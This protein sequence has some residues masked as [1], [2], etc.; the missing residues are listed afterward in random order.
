MSFIQGAIFD[1][2]WFYNNIMYIIVPLIFLALFI[3]A[4]I[5]LEMIVLPGILVIIGLIYLLMY[6][7]RPK[8]E[9]EMY[10]KSNFE[11]QK[12]AIH[13]SVKKIGTEDLGPSAN[14]SVLDKYK[15]QLGNISIGSLRF[16]HRFKIKDN[17]DL[18]LMIMD[19]S[20]SNS[21]SLNNPVEIRIVKD[22]DSTTGYLD[23]FIEKPEFANNESWVND[24]N[25]KKSIL[26]IERDSK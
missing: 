1:L 15:I 26:V 14:K 21:N 3:I 7:F 20:D 13:K 2:G 11:G 12:K 23:T 5:S 6:L 22:P 19:E 24:A 17:R 16:S 18:I 25:I 9:I 10:E 4:F 8:Y